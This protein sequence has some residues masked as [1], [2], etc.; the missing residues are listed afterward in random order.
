[1]KG[2]KN[3]YNYWDNPFEYWIKGLLPTVDNIRSLEGPTP[4][5][6]TKRYTDPMWPVLSRLLV[7]AESVIVTPDPWGVGSGCIRPLRERLNEEGRTEPFPIYDVAIH[8]RKKPDGSL[9]SRK[10]RKNTHPF[11][12]GMRGININAQFQSGEGEICSGEL[13]IL[14]N[15]P[16]RLAIW[17]QYME[18]LIKQ[19]LVKYLPYYVIRGEASKIAEESGQTYNSVLEQ[20]PILSNSLSPEIRPQFE[21]YLTN[22][23]LP[24]HDLTLNLPFIEGITP[25]LLAKIRHDNQDAF[26]RF[27]NHIMSALEAIPEALGSEDVQ[28]AVKKI[29]RDFFEDGLAH[30]NLKFRDI[31]KSRSLQ[32]AGC[33]LA[34]GGL[35]AS[36]FLG[37]EF[38]QILRALLGVG[39]VK[40][41]IDTTSSYIS[42]MSKLKDDKVYF[43][44]KLNRISKKYRK[45]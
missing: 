11:H 22:P 15:D 45:A 5:L 44:W 4:V 24:L 37:E 26:I 35:V 16:R 8:F 12:V 36:A 2:N 25:R 43:L 31:L 32:A 3:I 9:T 14:I 34:A 27:R 1:M 13:E 41:G 30:L 39:S 20:F 29:K 17:L 33:A 7:I 42:D 28:K 6:Q 38:N 18:P 19:G 40:L 23:K 21:S 10:F